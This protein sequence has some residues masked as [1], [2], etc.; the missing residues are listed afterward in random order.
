[1]KYSAVLAVV[2]FFSAVSF[3]AP[4]SYVERGMAVRRSAEIEAATKFKRHEVSI[5]S[6]IE[7]REPCDVCKEEE[8]DEVE[9]REA[10]DDLA[11]KSGV[12]V[13][14]PCK[15]CV[16]D[17]EGEVEV[18]EADILAT[19]REIEARKAEGGCTEC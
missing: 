15:E 9:V 2:G 19:K 12:E 1:M 16:E 10:A 18:R 3:A 13:R 8:G 7:A 4:L 5:E 11:A 17:E 6:E 14:E